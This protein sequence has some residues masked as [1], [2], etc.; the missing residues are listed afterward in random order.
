MSQTR[1]AALLALLTM[2]AGAP[3]AQ[4]ASDFAQLPGPAP[5]QSEIVPSVPDDAELAAR[6]ARIGRID[7]YIDDVFEITSRLTAPYRVANGLHISTRHSTVRAQILF[8]TGDVFDSRVLEESARILRSQRYFGDATVTPVRYD[9][10]S[11]T[12]DVAVRV[13]DVWTLSPGFSFGRKGGA[14][15]TRLEFEDTNLLGFGKQLSLSRA[16]NVDRSAWRLAYID[17][18]VLGSRWRFAGAYA[19]LSDGDEQMLSAARPFYSLDTRWSFDALA[20]DTSSAVPR[21]SLGEA[22]EEFQMQQRTLQIGGGVSKGLQDGWV[23]RY[24][25]GVR[26]DSRAFSTRAGYEQAALPAD[27]IVSYPWVGVELIEDQYLRTRNLDQIGRTEDF[28]LGR[29]ARLEVGYASTAFGSTRDAL[30]LNGKLRAGGEPREGQYIINTLELQSRLE[31]GAWRNAQLDLESR[32]FLRQSARRVFF[33]AASA[34][35]SEHLDEE[36]Q[37]LL[38][39]DNGLRGYPLRYQAGTARALFTLE[40]RFYSNWQPLKLF[41]VGAAVF[42]DAGRTWGRDEF[43]GEP[44][45][46]LKDIG[47]GLRLGSARSGLGNVLHIDLAFPLDGGSDIDSMQLLI[48]TRRSF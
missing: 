27:R 40:E 45:G 38:G 13:R 23:R 30:V 15:T 46:W 35:L 41:N 10:A 16:A 32:Y 20:L 42:F 29:S 7:V 48:E 4:T 39:G 36:Q 5:W 44:L 37:L 24:L 18:N 17:P 26:Y 21:Y 12:V 14:N 31:G 8:D 2:L 28:Y 47:V 3:C 33:A 22:V 1:S 19:S 25:G 9:E 6:G 43:A 11:N 34:S